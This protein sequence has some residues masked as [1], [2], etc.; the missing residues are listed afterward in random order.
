MTT[1]KEQEIDLAVLKYLKEKGYKQAGLL[2]HTLSLPLTHI[3]IHSHSHT[4]HTIHT[5]IH[6]TQLNAQYT[7][8]HTIQTYTQCTQTQHT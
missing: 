8:K 3:L 2:I 1:T 6:N 7:D 5:Q 4:M